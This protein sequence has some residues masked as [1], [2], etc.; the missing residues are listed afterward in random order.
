MPLA[1][2]ICL[3]AVLPLLMGVWILCLLREHGKLAI[4]DVGGQFKNLR[5]GKMLLLVLVAPAVA[6][7][8]GTGGG[9]EMAEP[10]SQLSAAVMA[11]NINGV[12]WHYAVTNGEATIANNDGVGSVTAVSPQTVTRLSVPEILYEGTNACPVTAIAENAFMGLSSLVEIVVPASVS[13]ID[14]KAFS[15]C[16]KIERAILPAAVALSTLMPDSYR[17]LRYVEVQGV[18]SFLEEGAVSVEVAAFAGCTSLEEV[19]LPLGVFELPDE[20]FSG[21]ASLV[22]FE[23]PYT[24]TSIGERAF[25]GCTALKALTVTENVREIGANAFTD[26][27]SLKVVR[28]L[29]D[30]P[31]VEGGGTENIY[32]HANASLVSGFLSGVRDWPSAPVMEVVS[33]E[34]STADSGASAAAPSASNTTAATTA[35]YTPANWPDGG[36][37]RPLMSWNNRL[38]SFRKVTLDYNDGGKTPATNRLY[39]TGRVLG[40]LPDPEAD[41]DFE[42]WFT[43]RS[44]GQ[45]ADPYGVV[46]SSITF[47]A[48]WNGDS[49]ATGRGPVNAL[50]PLYDPDDGEF[51]FTAATFDGL[52]ISDDVVAGTVQ[53]TTKKGRN[54]VSTN[55]NSSAFNAA[56]NV[57]GSKKVTLSGSIGADGSAFVENEGKGVSLELA[58]TQFGL[59]GSYS[60]E[61]GDYT[62]IGARDRYS[63]TSDDAKAKV[64]A[65]LDNAKSVWAVVLP[66]ESADGAGAA[67]STGYS[68]LSVSIGNKG[69]AK[70]NGTMADGS[71]VSVSSTLIVG[72]S[73]CCLPVMIPLYSGRSGGFSFAMWFTWSEDP[74]ERLVQVVGLSG[75][76][77]AKRQGGG[78][79]AEFGEPHVG[80]TGVSRVPSSASFQMEDFF[81]V[82]GAYS[83]MSPDGTE[84]DASGNVWRLPKADGVKYSKEDGW[85]TPDGK[86]HGNP[87][88]LKLTYTAKTGC[89]KG[90][91]KVFAETDEGKSKKLSA[92]VF[93]AVVDGVGYGT[94]TV[95]KVGSLPVTVE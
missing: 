85:Y 39:V 31:S 94:A 91:F 19:V 61:M 17:S 92:T 79:I 23:M 78:F 16:G 45:E 57:L 41:G 46:D 25:L 32:Y 11:T 65:A 2:Q 93:G 69:K 67:F 58:F 18:E 10:V 70:I 82:D 81:D 89:F 88:G 33:A 7:G 43:E 86:D 62:I 28:Y 37:G 42:G 1:A 6:Y 56:L 21:C 49:S 72:D 3:F 44:G 52:L 36:A 35:T 55:G 38:Y 48:H 40:E 73:C 66:T 27:S 84:I 26:C 87:A 30:E 95:K 12:T 68:V 83:E 8:D 59:S 9:A 80:E 75:W 5:G 74:S 76:Q 34:S 15:G 77:A 24:V 4:D 29:G 64:R 71:K 63:A 51:A 14:S 20:C 22:S 53:V 90:S 13:R 54:T 60:S 47:Y 50:E